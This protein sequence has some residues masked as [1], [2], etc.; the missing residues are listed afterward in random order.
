VPVD[1]SAA[2]E[3]L[4]PGVPVHR[5]RVGDVYV[6]QELKRRG[7]DFGGEPSGT[8]IFPEQTMC[9]DG[10]FAAAYLV[11]LVASRS[12]KDLVAAAPMYPVVRGS[13]PFEASRRSSLES[14]VGN[15]IAAMGKEV[16][17]LDGWRVRFDD[18]WALVRFSG[19]EPKIRVTAE[20]RQV[21]RAK[22]I[23]DK[24][25]AVLREAVR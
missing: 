10:P 14:A 13:L 8:F 12:L 18:G 15:A 16:S 7:A 2:F 5:T 25:F 9:P 6:A 24:V 23:Y 19:T 11:S 20:A 17:T 22:E 21:A 3:D 1:A 4:L